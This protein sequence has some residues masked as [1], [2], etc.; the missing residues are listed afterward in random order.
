MT[1]TSVT[2]SASQTAVDSTD[3]LAAVR[4]QPTYTNHCRAFEQLRLGAQTAA[5]QRSRIAVLSNFTVEPVVTC[6]TVQAVL[7]GRPLELYVAPYNEHAQEILEPERGLYRF[8]PEVVLALLTARALVPKVL[9]EPWQDSQRRRQ[10][11]AQGLAELTGWLASLRERSGAAILVSNF[12]ADDTSPLGMLEWQEPMGIEQAL[13]QLNHGLAEW[14]HGQERVYVVDLAGLCDRFGRER[15]FDSRLRLLADQPFATAFLP[16]LGAELARYIRAAVGTPRK[17]LVLDLDNTLWGGILG[18][19]GPERLRLGGD[20]VGEAYREF[21]QAILALHHRGVLLAL[22]SR[23]DE[24]DVLEVLR[25]HPGMLLRPHHFA[26]I[27][28]NWS[29][30]VEN[31]RSLAR[32]LNI[33]LDSLAFVDDDPF[34]RQG[35]RNRLPEVFVVDLPGDPALYRKT[36]LETPIFDTLN[37]TAE[38]RARGRMYQERRLHEHARADAPSLE[39]YLSGLQMEIVAVPPVGATRTRLFQLVH[40]TNQFNL[41]TRRYTEGEFDSLLRAPD[42]RVF[43]VQVRDRLG[44]SG[45]VGLMVLRLRDELCEV[46]DF[47]LS[48]RVLGRSIDSGVLSYAVELARNLGAK[49]MRGRYVAS[50]KN[51]LVRDLYGRHGFRPVG[52]EGNAQVWEADLIDFDIP[53]PPWARVQQVNR[54]VAQ[55]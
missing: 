9:A 42:Y 19:D 53:A 22:C 35:V 12:V 3:M 55:Q 2:A 18:E 45:V 30:K 7:G 8:N 39:A 48:C 46:E 34:E 24:N 25:S 47:L 15:A 16:R 23:N 44:D 27:R 37:V 13:Q 20:A 10:H 38:D 36:L 26:A 14:A 49:R 6:L 50:P 31:I 29:D 43:G 5:E 54:S 33:G 52:A 32:E 40:K 17:C 28:V 41:T 11:V 21:Q 51:E 4:A 1:Q